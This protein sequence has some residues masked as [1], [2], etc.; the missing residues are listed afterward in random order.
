VGK[1]Q[2]HSDLIGIAIEELEQMLKD[3]KTP[4]AERLKLVAEL[5]YHKA[6]NRQKRSK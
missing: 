3:K 1:R 4:A 5:K 2:R 6:R